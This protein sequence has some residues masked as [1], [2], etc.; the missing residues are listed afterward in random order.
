MG[1]IPSFGGTQRL[2]HLIGKTK[3]LEFMMTGNK[4][5]AEEAEELGLISYVASYKEALIKKSREIL[6]KIMAHAPTAIGMLVNCSNA[7]YNPDENG[8]QIEANS[9]A[10]C[11]KTENFREGVAALVEKRPPV[12][13]EGNGA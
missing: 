9:F 1:I 5:T 4:L 8:Y 10:N 2:T 12:F 6:Q 13:K 11:C 7:A 3:A